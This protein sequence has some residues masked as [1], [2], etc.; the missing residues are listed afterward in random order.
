M[1]NALEVLWKKS[2]REQV[3]L[4]MDKIEWAFAIIWDY[5]FALVS[6]ISPLV[7]TLLSSSRSYSITEMPLY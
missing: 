7:T 2:S 4:L 5:F 3:E 1:E 6:F